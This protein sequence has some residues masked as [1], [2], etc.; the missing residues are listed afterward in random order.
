MAE[1]FS[2]KGGSGR[3]P[4]VNPQD[5]DGLSPLS[6]GCYGLNCVNKRSCSAGSDSRG[7]PPSSPKPCSAL[8]PHWAQWHEAGRGSAAHTAQIRARTL[9]FPEGTALFPRNVK[10][11]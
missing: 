1:M 5:P 7:F 11:P 10:H 2:S 4:Q 3:Y 9:G 6:Q 8:C